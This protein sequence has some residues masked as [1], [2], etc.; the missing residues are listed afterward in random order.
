MVVLLIKRLCLYVLTYY[1]CSVI[2]RNLSKKVF[3]QIVHSRN[4]RDINSSDSEKS[5]CS[6][7]IEKTKHVELV[8]LRSVLLN[9]QTWCPSDQ[10]LMSPKAILWRKYTKRVKGAE[11]LLILMPG[12]YNINLLNMGARRFQRT[13]FFFHLTSNPFLTPCIS[14]SRSRRKQNQ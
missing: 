11:W 9:D 5:K 2:C 3:S 6:T 14:I 8:A 10:C 7:S 13:V 1:L 4:T 12:Q